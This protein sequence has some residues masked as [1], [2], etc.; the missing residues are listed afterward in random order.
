MEKLMDKIWERIVP[1]DQIK[2]HRNSRKSN[3]L[4]ESIE[5]VHMERY[6]NDGWEIDK[7]FKTKVRVRK[8]KPIDISFEDEV[9]ST[10]ADIGFCYLNKDRKFGITNYSSINNFSKSSI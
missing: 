9:W 10:M 2:K 8:L 5:H 7:E 1:D 3:Y 4:I 6:V